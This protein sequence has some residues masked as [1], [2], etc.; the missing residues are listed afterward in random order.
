[1]EIEGIQFT[2][3]PSKRKTIGVIVESDGKPILRVPKEASEE[4][5]KERVQRRLGWVRRK[6][7]L[8][9]NNSARAYH[10]EYSIDSQLPY[11]GKF[12]SIDESD[13]R[14]FGLYRGRFCIPPDSTYQIE[15]F[16][17][18]WY[19]ERANEYLAKRL[20]RL[21]EDY[22]ERANGVRILD[23]KGR[24][25]SCSED[26]T[27]N[28]N[29]KLVLLPVRLVDY[30]LHHE[31]CHLRIHNHSDRYWKHLS[32]NCPDWKKLNDELDERGIEFYISSSNN[33]DL[34]QG[35]V[36]DTLS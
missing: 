27:I 31:L 14:G 20:E 26:G 19:R 6:I 35:I 5:I 24:W 36:N 23:L 11:L 32:R 33:G 28:L 22:E 8:T 10:P 4:R 25:A 7:K 2:V 30:V 3:I 12:Y 15:G 34:P 1:M 13:C 9:Q 18:K 16:A 21:Q 17:L 29:W